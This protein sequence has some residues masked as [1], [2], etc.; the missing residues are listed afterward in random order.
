[1]LDVLA[2]TSLVCTSLAVYLAATGQVLSQL[3]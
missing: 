1:L 3:L 2:L